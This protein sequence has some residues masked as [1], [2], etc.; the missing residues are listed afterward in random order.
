LRL[1]F[2]WLSSPA[3][4]Q[5]KR[6]WQVPLIRVPFG[7]DQEIVLKKAQ[8]LARGDQGGISPDSFTLVGSDRLERRMKAITHLIIWKRHQLTS[9][10]TEIISI[11]SSNNFV[12]T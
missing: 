10:W 5:P 8:C 4:Q 9:N 11:V 1:G 12:N 7:R 3:L 6:R 2:V